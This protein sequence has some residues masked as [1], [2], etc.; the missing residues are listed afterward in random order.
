MSLALWPACAVALPGHG[1]REDVDQ[2]FTSQRP[3]SP[4]GASY[5][6]VYHAAGN[7]N[8]NPPYLTKM[9]FI[10]PKGLRYDTSVPAKCTASD[11]ELDA[12]GKSA[13]PPAS[14]IGG[15]VAEGIFYVPINDTIVF[16]R[17]KHALDVMNNTNE[18]IL[19][20][21]AEGSGVNRGHIR[22]DNSIVFTPQTCFPQPPTGTC[23]DDYIL[24]L[25]TATTLARYTRSVNGRTRSY[26]TTPPGCP[27]SRRWRTTVKIWWSN[28]KVDSV[29]TKQPCRRG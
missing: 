11:V 12:R 17:Y 27:A 25:K 1:P 24:Q 22:P 3:N 15:G 8:G 10:P 13:C 7:R 21:N 16:D 23:V 28:G 5:S 14:R 19:L 18:Q 2:R 4:T 20:V 6:G 9:V 26:A 29:V